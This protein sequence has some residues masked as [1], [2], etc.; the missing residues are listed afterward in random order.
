MM[1]YISPKENNPKFSICFRFPLFQSCTATVVWQAILCV[2]HYPLGKCVCMHFI[3][4]GVYCKG[5]NHGLREEAIWC[6]LD[7]VPLGANRLIGF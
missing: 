6:D 2:K 1:D 4:K 7:L 3:D 5:L